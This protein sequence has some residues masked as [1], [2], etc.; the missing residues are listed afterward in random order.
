MSVFD[1]IA[2]PY[3]QAIFEIAMEQNNI[4][5]W[6]KILIFI[7]KIASCKKIKNFLSGALAPKY[8]SLI[9]IT[10][11]ED[12][13]H[14]NAKNFIK[15]LAENQRFQILNNILEKFSRLE[16]Q[17]KNILIIEVSTACSLQEQ[18]VIKIKKI[19][20]QYFS[21]KVKL[22][23]RVDPRILGGIIIK[24][25]DIIFDFSI[26]NHLKQLSSDLYS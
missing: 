26:V 17:Y 15:L 16:T 12:I 7:N 13:V 20:E 18:D 3:A 10:I 8:L 14:E 23:C 6:K 9:F 25:D 19:L 1:T 4:E 5:E 2:R 24:K 11:S 22:V 21:K